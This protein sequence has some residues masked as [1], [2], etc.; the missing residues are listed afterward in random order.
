MSQPADTRALMRALGQLHTAAQNLYDLGYTVEATELHAV[1]NAL[2]D[3]EVQ[4]PTTQCQWFAL[5]DRPAAGVV[6]HPVLGQVPTC[7]RCAATHG[8]ELQGVA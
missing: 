4:V 7:S 8:L 6:A 2:Q 1:A 3:R 5:C